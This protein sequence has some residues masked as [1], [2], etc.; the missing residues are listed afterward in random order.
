MPCYHPIQAYWL[1]GERTSKGNRT[2][3][4][5]E[6]RAGEVYSELKVPCGQCIGCRLDRS[7]NWAIRCVHEA[8][9]HED[10]CFITLTYD[11]VK[12]PIHYDGGLHKR[13]FQLF[14]KKVRK[15]FDDIRIRYFHCGEYGERRGRPHYHAC[16]FGLDFKD[17]K[18]L[19]KTEV[20]NLYTSEIL[21]KLWGYGFC[22][23]GDVTFD[24]AAY[25][26]RYITK[27]ITG[28]DSDI[29][30][31]DLD[32]GLL[33]EKEYVTMSRRPGIGHDWLKKYARETYS[34]DSVIMNGRQV[35]PA[36]YYDNIFDVDHP[37]LF[38]KIKQNRI[39]K[40]KLFKE[41][42]T[43]ERLAVREKVA[44][45]KLKAFKRRSYENG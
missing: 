13:D 4:F 32:T 33:K 1:M 24:S 18:I 29:Y 44:T 7:R 11:D 45:A 30:Y 9:L 34:T 23:I 2:I 14:I 8:K 25:V 21:E 3:L 20:G 10:N 17:K 37:E 19:K 12:K 16:L 38:S 28:S 42:C 35:R 22:T 40:S 43:D 15:H 27:K 39:D 5:T 41:N 31:T 6:P 36:R 26:A